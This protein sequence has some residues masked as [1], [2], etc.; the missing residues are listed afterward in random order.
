M[1]IISKMTFK[2]Y[3]EVVARFAVFQKFWE[4]SEFVWHGCSDGA[5]GG[6]FCDAASLRT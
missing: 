6:V 2:G 1:L 3:Y 5:A 4:N